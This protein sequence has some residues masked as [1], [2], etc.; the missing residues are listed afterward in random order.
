[1]K[2]YADAHARRTRQI[3]ADVLFLLWLL[4]WVWMGHVVQHGTSQLAGV[5]RQ[6]DA[7]ASSLAAGL[8]S[9]SDSLRDLPVVGGQVSAPFDQMSSASEQLAAAGRTQVTM[10]NRLSWAL[11]IS[12]A[13]IPIL[14]VGVFFVP[15]RWRFAREA[16]AGSRFIDAAAD[17]DLFALRALARQ[18]MHVLAR[19]S[20]DPAGAWR[21]GD[22][23]VVTAL[24]E[25]ELR[26]A[27]LSMPARLR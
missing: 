22:R 15:A 19:V 17:L 18:P 20:D 25:L 2:L 26:D 21:A 6:T 23:A 9:A 10:V 5:G 4:G 16:T 1:M 3:L 7:S 14:S 8:T 11:G 13:V 24:A 12:I 27:G